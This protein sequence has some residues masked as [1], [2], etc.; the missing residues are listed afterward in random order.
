MFLLL[1]APAALQSAPAALQ[2]VHFLPGG[3]SVS[4]LASFRTPVGDGTTTFVR[5]RPVA[6][7][8]APFSAGAFSCPGGKP[9]PVCEWLQRTGINHQ[10]SA[11]SHQPST[12]SH[13][14]ERNVR[15]AGGSQLATDSAPK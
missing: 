4:I 11:I 13:Q 1:A 10:P 8:V 15:R 14:P 5:R 7:P 2:F 9:T 12:I 6:G 3:L